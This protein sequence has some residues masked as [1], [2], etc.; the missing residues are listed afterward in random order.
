M[1]PMLTSYF[2]F[3]FDSEG[4]ACV[5]KSLI[6]NIVPSNTGCFA[7]SLDSSSLNLLFFSTEPSL[8]FTLS[9]FGYR[10]ILPLG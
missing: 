6:S 4:L 7:T 10:K 1:P 2:R 9:L 5:R 8:L 3:C